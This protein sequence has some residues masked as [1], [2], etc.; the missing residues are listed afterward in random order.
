MSFYYNFFIWANINS[1]KYGFLEQ[2]PFPVASAMDFS[3]QCVPFKSTPSFLKENIRQTVN[4]SVTLG[5]TNRNVYDEIYP[6]LFN[7]N[8]L[9]NLIFSSD[10]NKCYKAICKSAT[11]SYKNYNVSSLKIDFEC[12]P[13]RY[14]VQNIP[15]TISSTST[16]IVEGNY[17]SEPCI[18]INGNGN[19]TI[20]INNN[21]ISVYVDGYLTLDSERLLAYK[22]N[23]VCL[24]QIVGKFPVFQV[25]ENSVSFDGGI[26][27]LEIL[28]NERWI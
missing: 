7:N 20:T 22:D 23:V 8:E 5:L 12:F 14:N 13:Y 15:L 18:K 4:V 6:W 3:T 27:S 1:S 2:T 21:T 16:I 10:L 17:Y 24:N 26:T 28:K 19:G 25:G 9:S 11:P